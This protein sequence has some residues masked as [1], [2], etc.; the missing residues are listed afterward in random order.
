MKPKSEMLTVS[1]SGKYKLN[2]SFI[3][4]SWREIAQKLAELST[5]IIREENGKDL[6]GK[7]F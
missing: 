5:E 1:V 3:V 4:Y 7:N 2:K 6:R